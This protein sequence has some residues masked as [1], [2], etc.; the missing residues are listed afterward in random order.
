M[1]SLLKLDGGCGGEVIN[2][3]NNYNYDDDKMLVMTNTIQFKRSINRNRKVRFDRGVCEY[4][5]EIMISLQALVAV[6]DVSISIL[7]C[8]DRIGIV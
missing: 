3:Y 2:Y 5:C 7:T 1:L 6:A 8:V 4:C